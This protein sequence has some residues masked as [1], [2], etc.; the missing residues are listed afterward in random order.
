M[1]NIKTNKLFRYALSKISVT[2][3]LAVLVSAILISVFNDVYAFV[4]PDFH[5]DLELSSPVTATELSVLLQENGIIENPH[6]FLIYASITG[7]TKDLSCFCGTAELNSD[8]SYRE[9]IGALSN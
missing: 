4:K 6:V 3:L 1:S 2:V 7:K 5:C 8:M 9:I